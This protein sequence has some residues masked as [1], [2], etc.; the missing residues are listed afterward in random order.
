MTS[1]NIREILLSSEGY[2]AIC[3]CLATGSWGSATAWTRIYIVYQAGGKI[4]RNISV[5]QE[6]TVG[7]LAAELSTLSTSEYFCRNVGPPLAPQNNQLYAH[8]EESVEGSLP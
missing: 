2:T 8:P 7:C 6:E 3:S 4:D 5:P 1:Q